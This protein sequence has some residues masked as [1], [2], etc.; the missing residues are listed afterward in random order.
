MESGVSHNAVKQD[1]LDS[2]LP[3]Q[4]V[5]AIEEVK[6]GLEVMIQG[7]FSM[8]GIMGMVGFGIIALF[9]FNT[10]VLDVMS[11]ETEFVNLRSLGS[12]KGKI[13]K[14]IIFQ[15]LLIAT[16]GSIVAVPLGYYI[17]DIA[18]QAM[19]KDLMYI[20]T[21]IFPQ[22]YAYSIVIAISASFIGIIAAIR[23][24]NKIDLVDALRTRMS[25]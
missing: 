18:M 14:I 9:S 15:G 21:V 13:A 16:L 8:M 22:S 23:R 11:R 20:P 12:G 3:I 25:N 6:D 4:V 2:N 10:I 5:I 1:L 24:V 7:I 17:A 19:M